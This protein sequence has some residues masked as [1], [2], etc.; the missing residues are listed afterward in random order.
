MVPDPQMFVFGSPPPLNLARSGMFGP[1]LGQNL[2]TGRVPTPQEILGGG[3]RW[4][5]LEHYFW[6]NEN[7]QVFFFWPRESS[8]RDPSL[9]TRLQ[10]SLPPGNVGGLLGDN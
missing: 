4:L 5:G 9:G 2:R 7:V 6:L 3:P 1:M 10:V 8:R